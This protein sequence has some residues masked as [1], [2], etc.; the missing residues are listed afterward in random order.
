[1]NNSAEEFTDNFL[2]GKRD[3]SA[4]KKFGNFCREI[5][6]KRRSPFLEECCEAIAAYISP[7]D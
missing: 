3:Y 6:K 5:G 7:I 2:S 4:G 1:M